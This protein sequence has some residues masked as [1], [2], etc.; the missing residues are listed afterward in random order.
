MFK[1]YLQRGRPRFSHWVGKILWRRKWQPTPLLLPGK[2]HGRSLVGYSPWGHKRVGHDW[3][4]SLHLSRPLQRYNS[5]FFKLA[6]SKTDIFEYTVLWFYGMYSF[7]SPLLQSRYRTYRTPPSPQ[8]FFCAAPYQ[9]YPCPHPVSGNYWFVLCQYSL[10]FSRI[11]CR[12][13]PYKMSSLRLFHSSICLWNSSNVLCASVVYSFLFIY[14]GWSIFH[15]VDMQ[16]V[17]YPFIMKDIWAVTSFLG[18]WTELLWTLYAG[19]SSSV[20]GKH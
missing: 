6:Y 14:F 3:A 9:S 15:C 10:A 8:N 19:Q 17:C 1:S 4:T 20:N 11:S 5:R 7:V 18:L 12:R 2:S 13:N 16:I